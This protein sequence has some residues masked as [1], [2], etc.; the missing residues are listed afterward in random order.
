MDLNA[1]DQ[2]AH[3]AFAASDKIV[4]PLYDGHFMTRE[5]FAKIVAAIKHES[6]VFIFI[7]S[8]QF[9]FSIVCIGNG[10]VIL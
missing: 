4:F 5:S 10:E 3:L 8:L 7:D 6:K 2:M 1:A 9:R